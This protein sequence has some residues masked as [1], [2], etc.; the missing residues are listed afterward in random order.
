MVLS[1]ALILLKGV[2]AITFLLQFLRTFAVGN[3][4]GDLSSLIANFQFDIAETGV[5]TDTALKNALA[6][7][8]K[9]INLSEVAR[10]SIRNMRGQELPIQLPT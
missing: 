3:N 10:T 6:I 2:P 8:A 5:I 1:T 9:T 7:S 4:A